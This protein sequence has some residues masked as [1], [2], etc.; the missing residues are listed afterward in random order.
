M[1]N[2]NLTVYVQKLI[3]EY[4]LNIKTK[5]VI[6]CLCECIENIVFNVVSIASVIAFINNSKNITKENLKILHSYINKSCKSSKIVKGGNSINMPAE[7][8]GIN[9]GR[10]LPNNNQVDLL[11]IN[12]NSGIARAQIGGASNK[13]PFAPVIKDFL[14]YYKLKA[15]KDVINEMVL[16]IETYIKCL[17]MKLKKCK[18]AITSKTIKDII[19]KNKMFKIFN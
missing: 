14:A 8:Y 2:S 10:Y 6:K 5:A 16:M 17:M 7:F 11:P 18:T 12:F 1:N 9:S 4:D 19:N 3:N 15:S 13:S